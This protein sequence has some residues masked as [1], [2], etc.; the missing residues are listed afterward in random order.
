MRC[1]LALLVLAFSLPAAA[2]ERVLDFN[3]TIRIA[4]D[5]ELTVTERIVVQVEGREIRRGILRDFPT[6]YRDRFGNRVIVPFSVVGVKRNGTRE[7]WS[8]ERL[9]NG[10]RIRIGSGSVM[11]P[12][13]EH[14]YEI[15]YRTAYQVGHFPD[16]DELYWNVN[17]NGWTF[18]FD[19]I[20]AEVLLP[21]S[22]PANELRAEAYTGAQGARGREYRQLIRDGAVGFSSTVAFAPHEGMTIVVGFP[23]GVV[24]EP[25]L[26]TRAGWF[27]RQNVG[28]AAGLAGFALML[29]FLY[30]RWLVVGRDPRAGPKFP[31]Y[32]P[33][34]GMSPA[35]VRFVDR[36]GFDAK[37][38]PA[39]LL[40]LGSRGLL[41]ITQLGDGFRL[42]PTGKKHDLLP[43]E[44]AVAGYAAASRT[45]G[46]TYDA[47]VAD[48]RNNL[49]RELKLLYE[50]KVFSR[51]YGSLALGILLGIA[52]IGVM[53]GLQASILVTIAVGIAIVL[54]L[55]AFYKWLPA[56]SPNGRRVEDEIEGL[57]E[58]LGVAE[59]DELARKK[60]PPKTPEEFSRFLPYAFALDVEKTWADRFALALGAAAVA[61]AVSGWYT[62]SDGDTSFTSLSSFTDSFSSMS[63]TISSAST[64][65]GSSSGSSDSGG[66]GGGSSGG[67]GG[68]G[69]GSGW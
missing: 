45:I 14:S 9:S 38:F 40:G 61:Q 57:R 4:Q 48:I 2:I 46:S 34:Q 59:R 51:N 6:D 10:E 3:S 64:A 26:L 35:A 37:C 13:G 60:A 19:H 68:G 8:Q 39:A 16:H 53:I 58:Y 49:E 21:K 17:G 69:G 27:L 54:T 30:W 63:D 33:P 11:L 66:G 52:T 67:G 56:Y 47:A 36:Q 62:S 23:K 29:G 43:G 20:S 24:H 18:A 31:R 22:I 42:D 7:P 44:H 1:W 25:A 55:V 5:G 65:P 12:H 32:D 50:E 28:V 15:T 41:K